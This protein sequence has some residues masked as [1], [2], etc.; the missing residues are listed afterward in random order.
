[1]RN[2]VLKH[3]KSK[4]VFSVTFSYPANMTLETIVETIREKA[5]NILSEINYYKLTGYAL[6]FRKNINKSE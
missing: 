4:L 3:E 6:Q 1:M 5:K 2:F